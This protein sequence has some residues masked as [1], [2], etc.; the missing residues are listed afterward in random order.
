MEVP[1][2]DIEVLEI[3][4]ILLKDIVRKDG[5]LMSK[6]DARAMI[7]EKH[8]EWV[9]RKISKLKRKVFEDDK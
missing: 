2:Y 1:Y 5:T 4:K 8:P 7:R 9:L 6:D 3:K